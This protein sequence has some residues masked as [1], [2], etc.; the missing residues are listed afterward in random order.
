M[1][2]LWLQ[3]WSLAVDCLKIVWSSDSAACKVNPA[4]LYTLSR[5]NSGPVH[6]G[7]VVDDL[8]LGTGCTLSNSVLPFQCR[9][10][11]ASH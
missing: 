2:L 7:F 11:S 10:T 1:D 6:V 5:T 8:A 9:Y 3:L 4:P